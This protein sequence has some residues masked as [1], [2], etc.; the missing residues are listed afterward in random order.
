MA[1]PSPFCCCL[2]TGGIYTIP[3]WGG[4]VLFLEGSVE[5]AD[6]LIAN[7]S[8]DLIHIQTGIFQHPAAL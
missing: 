6:I 1:Q 2:F 8:G 7:V 4:F 5:I 3:S